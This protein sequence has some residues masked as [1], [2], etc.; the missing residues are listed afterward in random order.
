VRVTQTYIQLTE[1]RREQDGDARVSNLRQRALANAKSVTPVGAC[2]IERC[3]GGE[4]PVTQEAACIHIERDMLASCCKMP[5]LYEG[6]AEGYIIEAHPGPKEIEDLSAWESHHAQLVAMGYLGIS[7]SELKKRE[8]ERIVDP[9]GS[10]AVSYFCPE[11]H[12]PERFVNLAASEA[13]S[14]VPE[15]HSSKRFVDP[16]AIEHFFVP[17]LHSSER[18]VDPVGAASDAK[19]YEI[20]HRPRPVL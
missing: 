15:L 5:I 3:L 16:A 7:L 6:L 17:E 12:S 9:A 2:L 1:A 13:S 8:P 14:F 20:K 19:E 4:M 11:L 18:F 10:E